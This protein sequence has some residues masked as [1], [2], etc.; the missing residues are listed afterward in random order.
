MRSSSGK[1]GNSIYGISEDG[2][3]S[4]VWGVITVLGAWGGVSEGLV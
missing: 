2:H 3:V 4:L 1:E